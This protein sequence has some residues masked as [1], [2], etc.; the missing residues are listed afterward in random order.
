MDVAEMS[1]PKYVVIIGD[2]VKSREMQDRGEFQKRLKDGIIRVNE[3]FSPY[4]ASHFVLTIGDEFQG[5]LKNVERILQL[6]AILRSEIHPIE[7]RI[8]LGIGGLDTELEQVALGMDGPCFHRARDAIERA[9]A[10]Q[11]YIEVETG[12]SDKPFRIYSLLY[13]GIRRHWTARQRQVFDLAMTGM[14]GKTIAN[15]LGI[16]PSAVSQHLSAVG[17]NVLFDATQIWMDALTRIFVS[18]E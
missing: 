13:S 14:P 12:S 16:T 4:I 10:S 1:Q 3:E 18:V 6:L 2:V 8:G 11:T 15:R 17:A 5:L 7:Q 9:K